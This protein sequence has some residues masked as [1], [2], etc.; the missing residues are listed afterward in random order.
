MRGIAASFAIV[1]AFIAVFVIGAENA[2]ARL[3]IQPGVRYT[4]FVQIAQD[5]ALYVDYLAAQPGK[6]TA[7]L[8]NGLTYGTDEWD[9][10]VG[11]FSRDGLGI[12]RFD[13]VGQGETLYKFGPIYGVI[14]VRDQVR[15][16][17]NLLN[18]LGLTRPVHLVGLSYGG[19]VAMIFSTVYPNRVASVVSM[20]PYVA[21]LTTQD[22][23]IKLQ[24]RQTRILY[25]FNPAT[26]DELYDFFLR[27]IVYS[28]YPSVEPVILR[29]PYRLEAAYRL[30]QGIRK[31]YA[32]D[33]VRQLPPGKLH[34]VIAEKDQYVARVDHDTF[35]EQVPASARASRLIIKDSEHKI[36]EAVPAFSADWVRLIMDGNPEIRGGRDFIG[37]PNTGTARSGSSV[38]RGIGRN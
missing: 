1:F 21:P 12:L 30:A 2:Q 22:D 6:Q 38:I 34:L 24:I 29:H 31:F 5:R 3:N 13:F 8:V 36:P 25:P 15:D 33:I 11:S 9:S 37:D 27:M 16:M 28:T 35:W 17:A 4:G 19:A 10:F 26:D 14:D 18:A 32:K 20:A 23:W 7:V